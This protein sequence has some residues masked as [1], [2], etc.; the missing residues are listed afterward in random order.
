MKNCVHLGAAC[1]TVLSVI[2]LKLLRVFLLPSTGESWDSVQLQKDKLVAV[3]SVVALAH[4]AWG[5]NVSC[6]SSVIT[7][8]A[9]KSIILTAALHK[10]KDRVLL[11]WWRQGLRRQENLVN[12]QSQIKHFRTGWLT[13]RWIQC[14]K[15]EKSASVI[16]CLHLLLYRILSIFYLL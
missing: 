11:L 5:Q 15:Y 1:A 4:F 12:A 10:C 14:E 7:A 8:V 6:R 13:V 9:L 2:L 3:S 16:L